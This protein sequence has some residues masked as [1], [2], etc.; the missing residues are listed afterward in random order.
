MLAHEHKSRAARV[1]HL[2]VQSRVLTFLSALA[3]AWWY[4]ESYLL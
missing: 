3:G 4:V 1:T 2:A